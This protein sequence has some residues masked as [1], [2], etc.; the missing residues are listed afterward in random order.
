MNTERAKQIVDMLLR[1]RRLSSWE[2][3]Y[4][5]ALQPHTPTPTQVEVIERLAAK[6]NLTRERETTCEREDTRNAQT[7]R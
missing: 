4:L 6:Y 7:E 2:S 3:G 5:R 1:E